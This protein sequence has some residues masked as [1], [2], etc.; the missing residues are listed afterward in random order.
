LIRTV[1]DPDARHVKWINPSMAKGVERDVAITVGEGGGIWVNDRETGEFLWATPFPY[2]TPHFI[3]EDIDVET[4]VAH[5]NSK[6]LLDSP[7]KT[8]LV[9]YWNTRS[10]WPTAYSP[11]TNSLYVPYIDHCLSMTRATDS[12]AERRT[13]ALRPGAVQERLAGIAR[14]DMRTGEIRR[15]YEAPLAGNGAM[16]ATAGDLLFWGDIGQVLRAF[17]AETGRVLWE[18]EPLGATIQTSTITYAV[19]G[20]QYLAVVNAESLL[21]APR[22]AAIA[23]A[24]LPK[25]V[26]NSINVF[27]LPR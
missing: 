8:S 3:L 15:I 18:S 20:R 5:I 11:K 12:D 14:I 23:G 24:T 22:L 26:A 17:D 13:S 2:D 25:H 9:C 21:G 4:G 10:F 6:L 16:L 27:A 7:G 19:D 1:V